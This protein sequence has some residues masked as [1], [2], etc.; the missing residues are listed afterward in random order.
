LFEDRIIWFRIRTNDNGAGIGLDPDSQ[1]MLRI[2]SKSELRVV[3]KII[4]DTY[5]PIPY[6]LTYLIFKC[7]LSAVPGDVVQQEPDTRQLQADSGG[8]DR[9]QAFNRQRSSQ[10]VQPHWWGQKA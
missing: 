1:P 7:F 4:M 6:L 10:E 9:R 3:G 8:G 5:I 2:R